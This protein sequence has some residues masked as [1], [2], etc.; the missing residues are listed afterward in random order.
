MKLLLIAMITVTVVPR[1]E[2]SGWVTAAIDG[3]SYVK[4]SGHS[5]PNDT[6]SQGGQRQWLSS[7]ES[8]GITTKVQAKSISQRKGNQTPAVAGDTKGTVFVGFTYVNSTALQNTMR[9]AFEERLGPAASAQSDRNLAK[10]S[11]HG[12]SSEFASGRA[13]AQM[14][15]SSF[16]EKAPTP[17]TLR[18]SSAITSSWVNESNGEKSWSFAIGRSHGATSY[19][20]AN[21]S[22]GGNL[23]VAIG[24]GYPWST[25]KPIG[26][27]STSITSTETYAGSTNAFGRLFL[28][29]YTQYGAPVNLY[30]TDVVS[31]AAEFWVDD[32]A[33]TYHTYVHAKGALRK[34]LTVSWDPAS[35]LSGLDLN[36]KYGDL[37][38][39]N[40]VSQAEVDF[41]FASIG[42]TSGTLAWWDVSGFAPMDCDFNQDGT[43]SMADYLLASPN[44][45][46]TGDF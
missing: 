44:A 16:D 34:K 7:V 9:V 26:I 3:Q 41:V 10:A 35:G 17:K 37:N 32:A 43:V 19:A 30:C 21:G 5:L 20:N 38:G 2:P 11:G 8:D 15:G 4:A 18:Y 28:D 31:G 42:S 13:A 24:K 46:V 25:I 12:Q 40:Y 29:F 39:D 27:R 36:V 14:P 22:G 6:Q 1:W 33:G 23:T 45:G